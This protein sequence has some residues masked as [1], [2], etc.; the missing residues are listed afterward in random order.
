M[1]VIISGRYWKNEKTFPSLNDYITELGKNPKAGGR[2][3]SKYEK[4]ACDVLRL[5]FRGKELKPPITIHYR[6]YE[7]EKGQKRDHMNIFSF[8]DKCIQDALQKC[9]ILKNDSPQYVDGNKITHE[10]YYTHGMP[11]IEVEFEQ[12]G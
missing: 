3:K 8:A 9:G 5:V 4:I 7:P 2:M 11:R 6:F 10:F 12:L 1:I